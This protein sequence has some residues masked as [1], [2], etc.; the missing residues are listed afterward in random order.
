MF[1]ASNCTFAPENG[2]TGGNYDSYGANRIIPRSMTA[3]TAIAWYNAIETLVLIFIVFK[4]YSGLYFWSLL[5]TS[6]GIVPYASGAWM[7]QNNVNHNEHLT[8]ALLTIGWVIMVPGQSLVLYSR[9]HLISQHHKL[10]RF[11]LWIII[12]NA[13]VLCVPT[14][15]LNLRQFTKHP[16]PYSQG[17]VIMEKIQMTIFTAQE[18]F[19]SFVYFYE[20]RI[21]MKE[22]F[23]GATRKI[24]WQL[25]AMNVLLLVLDAALLTVE[26]LNFYMIETT[27]KSLVYS[28]KLKVEFGVLSQIVSIIQ[29]KSQENSLTLVIP[30]SKSSG[31]DVEAEAAST[32]DCEVQVTQRNLPPEWRLSMASRGMITPDLLEIQRGREIESPTHSL[33]SVEKMYPGRLG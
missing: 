20:I 19:I 11:I 2:I 26:F 32:F 10:L 33:S 28:V 6:L 14:S 25:V 13:V 9:L 7:K 24:M 29:S 3:F 5:I 17:Y 8:E 23:D 27:F 18:V 15:T 30:K 4:R 21:V 31:G 12:I 1:K 22:I 16:E